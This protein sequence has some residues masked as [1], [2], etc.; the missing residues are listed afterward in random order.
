[1]NT[2]TPIILTI[3]LGSLAAIGISVYLTL[4]K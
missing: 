4:K 1:M 2:V 3:V